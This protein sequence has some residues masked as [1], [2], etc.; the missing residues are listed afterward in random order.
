MPY[1]LQCKQILAAPEAAQQK[2]DA[3][4]YAEL[5]QKCL[6]TVLCDSDSELERDADGD[7]S[8]FSTSES[9]S[10]TTPTPPNL[11]TTSHKDN[12]DSLNLLFFFHRI[13]LNIEMLLMLSMI[14]SPKLVFLLP[15]FI[16]FMLLR[17]TF[18]KGGKSIDLASFVIN[19]RY[20]LRF[21]Q[22]LW[23]KSLIIQFSMVHL[24]KSKFGRSLGYLSSAMFGCL[25]IDG[26]SKR[27]RVI[28]KLS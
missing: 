4:Q 2:Y 28:F 19:F 15:T 14:K 24:V 11:T 26:Q 25:S 16:L 27:S 10:S 20:F 21:L 22:C 17:S 6:M 18:L 8:T 12:S 23:R 7:S 3:L 13:F 5:L 1:Q 9:T